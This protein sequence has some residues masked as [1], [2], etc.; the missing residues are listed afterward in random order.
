MANCL[1]WGYWRWLVTKPL[2]SS[3]LQE[4]KIIQEGKLGNIVIEKE[5]FAPTLNGIPVSS[6]YVSSTPVVLHP[7]LIDQS[8]RVRITKT[9]RNKKKTKKVMLL[10]KQSTDMAILLQVFIMH[11]LT[12]QLYILQRNHQHVALKQSIQNTTRCGLQN[13]EK[14]QW[15]KRLL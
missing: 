7:W 2:L 11:T 8:W 3:V 5:P 13:T 9:A 14:N 15:T 12:S 6:P 10:P 4:L 1:F